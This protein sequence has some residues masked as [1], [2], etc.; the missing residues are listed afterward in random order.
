MKNKIKLILGS[1][2]KPRQEILQDLG[3]KF[4]I[5]KPEINEKRVRYKDPKELVLKI[6]Q[7][8]AEDITKKISGGAVV[9]TSD[10]ISVVNGE[11]RGKP[12]DKEQAYQWIQEISDGA[13]QTQLSSVVVVN[14]KTGERFEGVEEASVIF[15]QIPEA[16]IKEFV[17][18][19]TAFNHAGAYAIQNPI[20]KRRIRFIKG[21][22]ETIMG[23]PKKLI[24]NLLGKIKA[25]KYY[26]PRL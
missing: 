19:G 7:A 9:I 5:I 3:Y 4:D 1:S 11:I 10:S 8:K 22:L 26:F 24:E 21:E 18:S 17:E 12:G 15:N 13:P 2:S 16:D 20:F 6:A 25:S 14:T 23:L